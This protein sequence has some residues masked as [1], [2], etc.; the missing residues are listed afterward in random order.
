MANKIQ[1]FIKI[2]RHKSL[3][4]GNLRIL[5]FKDNDQV[6]VYLPSLM[7]SGYG[8]T[9]EKARTMLDHQMNEYGKALLDLSDSEIRN[10]LGKYGWKKNQFFHKRFNHSKSYVDVKGILKDFDLQEET[11]VMENFLTV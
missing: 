4:T 5:E 3:F 1:E 6:V 9:R 11:P 7:M 2:N 10:E 8:N